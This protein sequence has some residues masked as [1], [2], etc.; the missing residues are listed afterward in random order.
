[1]MEV[2]GVGSLQQRTRF[3]CKFTLF[4]EEDS[5]IVL[6]RGR[7]TDLLLR[8]SALSATVAWA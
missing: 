7:L 3:L 5:W 8:S 2:D 1:M 4:A 6:L